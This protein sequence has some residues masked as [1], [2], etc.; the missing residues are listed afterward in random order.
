M[1]AQ[2]IIIKSPDT[3]VAVIGLFRAANFPKL[4][5]STSKK[6]ERL[7]NIT[8]MRAC[9]GG[10]FS[11]TLLGVHAFSGRD[12]V[13]CRVRKKTWIK[14]LTRDTQ[15]LDCFVNF[16]DSFSFDEAVMAEVEKGVCK[17][18]GC[19]S[20]S[21]VNAARH[22]LFRSSALIGRQLPPTRDALR[23]HIMR[24]WYQVTIWKKAL[25]PLDEAPDPTSFG[26]HKEGDGLI[27]VWMTDDNLSENLAALTRC[28]CKTGCTRSACS[29]VASGVSCSSLC[30]CIGCGNVRKTAEQVEEVY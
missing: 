18:Y 24:A 12:T 14:L 25:E 19:K 13:S 26:R 5:F 20:A 4:L 11:N 30:G 3:D 6:E 27:P 23:L 15:V 16:G 10:E 29:C 2:C 22:T 21:N 7:L 8:A 1:D 28:S 9:L 17:L